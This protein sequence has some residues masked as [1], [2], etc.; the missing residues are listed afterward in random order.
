MKTPLGILNKFEKAS[1]GLD[2]GTITLTLSI[3][4]GRR[5]YLIIREE[6]VIPNEE[7]PDHEETGRTV[8][9]TE[10]FNLFPLFL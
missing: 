6:S 5:R 2:Y 10:E 3:K 8:T 9:T 4:Q 1:Q 7:P